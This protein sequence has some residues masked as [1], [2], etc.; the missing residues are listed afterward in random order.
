[1][2]TVSVLCIALVLTFSFADA[3]VVYERWGRKTCPAGAV[4]L[5]K[6]YMASGKYNSIGSG[7]NFLCVNEDPLF[8]RGIPG[9]Q[10]YAGMIYGVEFDFTKS[11]YNNLFSDENVKGGQL[12][13]Q[14]MPCV[15]CYVAESY[16]K[17]VMPGRPDC[18]S[19]GF[20]LQYKGFLVSGGDTLPGKSEYVCLDEAPEGT[21]GGSASADQ[22]V[23]YPVQL[24][25]G[26]LPCNPFQEGMEM[27]CAVCTY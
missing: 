15:L 22:S 25:C 17:F 9:Q 18:G 21:V 1:M 2:S 13:E 16:T 24:G 6:G 10:K 14:D 26:S 27:T 5:Y 7:G 12:Q 3:S 23:I 8:V 4:L 11:E 19:T 20:D